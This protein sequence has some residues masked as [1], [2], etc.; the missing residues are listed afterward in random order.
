MGRQAHRGEK[1]RHRRAVVGMVFRSQ[2]DF[3][4]DNIFT[5]RP[6]EIVEKKIARVK[7]Y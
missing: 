7:N 3:T 2:T 5:R 4:L 1:K 6:E